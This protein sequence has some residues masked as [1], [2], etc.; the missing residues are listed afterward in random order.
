MHADSHGA[1]LGS[2]E[3]DVTAGF[4]RIFDLGVEALAGAI[5]QP[6]IPPHDRV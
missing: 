2:G 1:L 4:D 6:A 3:A 5:R